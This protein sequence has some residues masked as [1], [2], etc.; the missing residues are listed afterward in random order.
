MIRIENLVKN[1]HLEKQII[2][3]LRGVNLEINNKDFVI[4]YGRSGAGKSTLLYQMSLLDKPTS[5]KIFFDNKEVSSLSD[6]QR[7][8]FRLNKL[9]YIF[10]DYA[11]LPELTA[12]ENIALPLIMLGRGK[13]IAELKAK[14]I[15][16]ELSLDHRFNNLPNQLSGGEKQRV[17]VA[18]AIVNQPRV[19][20]ADEPTA[21]LDTENAQKVMSLLKKL[22]DQGQTIVLVTHE[23]EYFRYANKLIEV[24]DGK[25]IIK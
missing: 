1:Y 22:N 7:T 24:S 23:E 10:Q 3:V 2:E 18:R 19:I 6:Q 14:E 15:L 20:F 12:V 16:S 8:S 11:L 5:G 25:I 13:K 4:I 9:G 21:N 17:A